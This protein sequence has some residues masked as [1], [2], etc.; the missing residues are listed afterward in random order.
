MCGPILLAAILIPA[1]ELWLIIEIGSHIGGLTT[2]AL[3]FLTAA[4]GLAFARDQSLSTVTRL[5]E[6]TLPA[7]A[8]VLDGPLLLLAALCLLIPGFITDAIGALLLVP[9]LRQ[10]AARQIVDRFGG[11]PGPG[12]GQGTI[13]VVRPRPPRPPEDRP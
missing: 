12:G 7:D 11:P 9:P 8:A 13:I 1:V 5:R 4:V 3:V 2:V 6:G 10:A